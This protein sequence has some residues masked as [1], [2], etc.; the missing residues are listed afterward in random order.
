MCGK[1]VN[2]GSGRAPRSGWIIIGPRP[3]EHRHEEFG[4]SDTRGPE[5]F[6]EMSDQVEEKVLHH[7]VYLGL[8]WAGT[9]TA[10]SPSCLEKA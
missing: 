10:L 7:V 9:V 8:H 4:G 6:L 3:S 2:T 5:F 1:T